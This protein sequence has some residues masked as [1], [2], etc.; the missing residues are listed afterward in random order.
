[1]PVQMHEADTIAVE[2]TT[3]ASENDDE[4]HEIADNFHVKP[5][6]RRFSFGKIPVPPVA[7]TVS[8][9][10]EAAALEITDQQPQTESKVQLKP[11]KSSVTPDVFKNFRESNERKNTPAKEQIVHVETKGRFRDMKKGLFQFERLREQERDEA[12]QQQRHILV[13]SIFHNIAHAYHTQRAVNQFSIIVQG[14]LAGISLTLAVFAFNFAEEV[15]LRGYKWMSV[16]IHAAFV[17]AFTLGVVTS[18][19]RMGVYKSQHFTSWT[20]LKEVIVNNG[21]ISV[22]IWSVGLLATLMCI[23]F[24]TKLFHENMETVPHDLITLWRICCVIRAISASVG[25]L[26]LAF[27]PDS[28]IVSRQLKISL[29]ESIK[30]SYEADYSE[31]KDVILK[32]L[33]MNS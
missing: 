31:K 14:F 6:P 15:L 4:N 28:D 16:P 12:Y 20:H 25:W 19:D 2:D 7:L 11:R 3:V 1:M 9:I 33:R 5:A 18:I 8:N 22:I 29:L 21:F 30:R 32:A 24:D 17:A 13:P 27:R 23:R 26:F 10:Q